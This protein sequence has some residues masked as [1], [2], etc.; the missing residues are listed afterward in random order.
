M[1]LEYWNGT[2]ALLAAHNLFVLMVIIRE[3]ER[4]VAITTCVNSTNKHF[5]MMRSRCLN[6]HSLKGFV[7][8]LLSIYALLLTFTCWWKKWCSLP[9]TFLFICLPLAFT[10]VV[11]VPWIPYQSDRAWSYSGL[12][13]SSYSE[14]IFNTARTLGPMLLKIPLAL[15][16]YCTLCVVFEKLWG[17]LSF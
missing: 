7:V 2:T 13:G 12:G 14:L 4:C 15:S 11:L 16:F 1:L 10:T 9:S 6:W 8:P 3:R 17:I 5:A